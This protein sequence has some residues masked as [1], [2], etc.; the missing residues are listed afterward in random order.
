MEV[1]VGVEEVLCDGRVGAG[2]DLA[3]EIRQIILEIARLRVNFRI[4]G[5]F[6]VEVV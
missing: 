1:A 3:H 6:D 2:F 5:N 4:G